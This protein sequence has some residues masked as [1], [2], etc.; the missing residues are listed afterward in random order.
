[1]LT[2]LLIAVGL[3][4][5]L[6]SV[7]TTVR[8]QQMV[9]SWYGPGFEGATTASGEPF[10]PNDYTAAHKTLPFGTKLIVTYNGKSVV[11][12]VN[13]RGPHV[14]GRDIDLSQ[15]AAEYIGLTAVGSAVVEVSYADASTPVGP[16][17]G[18]NQQSTGSGTQEETTS[19]EQPV[20]QPDSSGQEGSSESGQTSAQPVE[21]KANTQTGSESLAVAEETQDGPATAAQ[22]VQYEQ[23]QDESAEET[24]PE[25]P[26]QSAPAATEQ[27]S[28]NPAG[29]ADLAVAQET[30]YKSN[31]VDGNGDNSPASES[32][33]ESQATSQ[34]A[35]NESATSQSQDTGETEKTTAAQPDQQG[36]NNDGGVSSVSVQQYGGD[37]NDDSSATVQQYNG[38]SG[39]GGNGLSV[40]PDTGSM[41]SLTVMAGGIVLLGIGGLLRKLTEW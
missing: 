12:R 30:Q 5:V 24:Q 41:L 6:L 31:T 17:S 22:G 27:G 9:A 37:R 34:T 33:R 4:L 40:L 20:T 35:S 7:S 28:G 13:D 11:V 8:A 15:A 14:E 38:Q 21:E 10:D 26:Q 36:S 2:F 18:A 39:G 23:S 1:M 25:Q 29:D 3:M 19:A 32:S 16:Y